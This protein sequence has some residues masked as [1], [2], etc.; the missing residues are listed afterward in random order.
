MDIVFSLLLLLPFA[1]FIAVRLTGRP[2]VEHVSCGRCRYTVEF[3]PAGY[4]PECGFN[5]SAAGVVTPAMGRTPR[6]PHRTVLNLIIAILPAAIIAAWMA[7]FVANAGTAVKL[8]QRRMVIDRPDSGA[9]QAAEVRIDSQRRGSVVTYDGVCFRIRHNDGAWSSRKCFPLAEPEFF[10]EQVIDQRDDSTVVVSGTVTPQPGDPPDRH[11]IVKASDVPFDELGR[12]AA[13]I[14]LHP[15]DPAIE[16]ELKDLVRVA[17]EFFHTRGTTRYALDH[18]SPTQFYVGFDM[19]SANPPQAM[20]LAL[21]AGA[22]VWAGLALLFVGSVR[23]ERRRR[24]AAAIAW[25]AD[26]RPDSAPEEPPPPEEP[27]ESS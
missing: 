12:W 1:V 26:S 3:A 4:C 25:L 13:A 10:Y 11:P 17:T 20:P 18:F 15:S 6:R 2:P 16:G 8:T 21:L 7:G 27:P 9:Y 19:T 5:L 24:R 14:G 23:R 22:V